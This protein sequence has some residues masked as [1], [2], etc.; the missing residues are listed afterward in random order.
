MLAVLRNLFS[1]AAIV[2][3]LSSMPPLATTIM[4]KYFPNRPTHPLAMLGLA[5]LK[6]VAQTIPV[7]RRDGTPIS[8]G[9]EE[10]EAQFIAPLPIKPKVNVS[11]SELNDLKALLQQPQA[12]EAWRARKLEKI[13]RTVRN[14]TEAIC[15][16]VLTTGKASWPVQL[17]GGKFEQ[18]EV[19]Y[20]PI[21]SFTPAAKLTSASPLSALYN[22]LRS[23][24]EK[25]K[26]AGG[27]GKIEFLAGK[28]V[29]SVLLDIVNASTTTTS[30]HPYKLELDSDTIKIGSDVIQ[31]MDETYPSPMGGAWVEK[32]DPKTLL[33]VAV[34]QPGT[35][36]YCAIDSISANNAA[37]P[38][39]VLPVARDD[40]TGITLIAN[41]KPLPARPS[42]AACKAVVVD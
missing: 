10:L 29:A 26:Q 22:L 17:E 39:H 1:P 6:D 24:R 30:K 20:G 16:I 2:Q 34:D 32:L 38:L 31:F 13:R 41:T 35:I 11:A 28:D 5:D 27:G 3:A 15:S 8:L 14:T 25:I 37:V 12:L 19:D 42:R 4:D 23:M 33:A 40:D 7:V 9:N 21:Q 18:Y 36:F